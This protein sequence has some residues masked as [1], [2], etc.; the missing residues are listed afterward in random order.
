MTDIGFNYVPD[1]QR[2]PG[3]YPEVEGDI[4][5]QP[6]QWTLMIG[7]AINSVSSVPLM[8]SSVAAAVRR[9]GAG[10]MLASMVERYLGLRSE[11][12]H[13]LGAAA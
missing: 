3:V 8:I 7:Q 13:A 5:G 10:S 2:V 11:P 1:N 4:P 9:F 12:R 6:P